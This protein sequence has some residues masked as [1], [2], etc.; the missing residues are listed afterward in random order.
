MVK[1]ER[2]G[3]RVYPTAN[4]LIVTIVSGL[5]QNLQ[6][7]NV[8]L[9]DLGRRL[10]LNQL[11]F[12]PLWVFCI[13][14]NTNSVTSGKRNNVTEAEKKKNLQAGTNTKVEEVRGIYFF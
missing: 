14:K 10:S 1:G 9:K 2:L 8:F 4:Y 11:S 3:E 5:D 6:P 13:Q 7:I 12:G